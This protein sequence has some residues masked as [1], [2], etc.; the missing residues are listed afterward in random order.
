MGSI[1]DADPLILDL[2]SETGG[3]PMVRVVGLAATW[4]MQPDPGLAA[5]PSMNTVVAGR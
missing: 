1:T 5:A 4:P 3:R 2:D